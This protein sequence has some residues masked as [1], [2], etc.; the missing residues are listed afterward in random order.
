MTGWQ[1]GCGSGG[2]ASMHQEAMELAR[3]VS[4]L[5]AAN[6]QLASAHSTLLAQLEALYHELNRERELRIESSRNTTARKR[7]TSS[8]E[9]E[10]KFKLADRLD[11]LEAAIAERQ[12]RGGNRQND[13]WLDHEREL[14][15][16]LEELEDR[17][18]SRKD[19][20]VQSN[21]FDKEL[22]V[23]LGSSAVVADGRV[24]P[25]PA[26]RVAKKR[27]LAVENCARRLPADGNRLPRAQRIEEIDDRRAN[28][29][30]E[31][32]LRALVRAFYR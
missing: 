5:A 15:V 18:S 24:A 17:L 3:T 10:E 27:N 29:S 7:P 8:D 4:H 19:A 2:V 20:C 23:R 11:K 30:A 6:Q 16:S 28:E 26:A 14:R 13:S 31:E 32:N 25:L 22:E 12:Y 9:D 21:S 1:S